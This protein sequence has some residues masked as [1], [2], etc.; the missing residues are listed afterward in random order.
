M[1]FIL[2]SASDLETGP[3]VKCY[4]CDIIHRAGEVFMCV[5][6]GSVGVSCRVLELSAEEMF[7]FSPI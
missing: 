5:S 2:S 3:K 1:D 7:A 4:N 6:Q